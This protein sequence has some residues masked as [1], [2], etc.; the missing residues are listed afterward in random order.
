[1]HTFTS[2]VKAY[3]LQI[4]D[5]TLILFYFNLSNFSILVQAS[6]RRLAIRDPDRCK[7]ALKQLLKAG[8]TVPKWSLFYNTN[9]DKDDFMLAAKVDNMD[10]FDKREMYSLISNIY[11]SISESRSSKH[12]DGSSSSNE[13]STS[14]LTTDSKSSAKSGNSRDN[15]TIDSAQSLYFSVV[16]DFCYLTLPIL[17]HMRCSSLHPGVQMSLT[18]F[19]PRYRMLVSEAMAGRKAS[20]LRG[21]LLKEPRPRFIFC[22]QRAMVHGSTVF[23]VEIT[24]CRMT[25]AGRAQIMINPIKKVKML[26][27]GLR[28]GVSNHLMDGQIRRFE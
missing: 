19:E 20:E 12:N 18:L 2:T 27:V 22:H 1:M 28:P 6:L 11:D 7:N 24:R 4:P 23:I 26:K 10:C 5:L 9:V 15:G 13:A 17:F 21:K 3:I 14:D 25:E 16:K 8:K